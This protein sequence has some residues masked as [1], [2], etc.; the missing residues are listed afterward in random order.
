MQFG[1]Q[2]ACSCKF[3]DGK[4]FD[5]LI[6]APGLGQGGGCKREGCKAY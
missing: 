6:E 4:S 2:D 3:Q 1:P 5:D